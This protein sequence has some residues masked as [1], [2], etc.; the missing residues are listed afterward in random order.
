MLCN[1]N[2]IDVNC[3]H[4]DASNGFA[5]HANSLAYQRIGERIS[6]QNDLNMMKIT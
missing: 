5:R 2:V 1:V 6:I 4:L 3:N